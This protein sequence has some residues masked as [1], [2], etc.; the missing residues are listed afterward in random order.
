MTL[1]YQTTVIHNFTH[2]YTRCSCLAGVGIICTPSPFAFMRWWAAF[3]PVITMRN[4]MEVGAKCLRTVL[5]SFTILWYI[6]LLL[7]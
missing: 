3:A 6:L 4:V 7:I 1:G 2:V 5:S